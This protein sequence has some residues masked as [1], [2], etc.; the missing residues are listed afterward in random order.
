MVLPLAAVANPVS[1]SPLVSKPGL[2]ASS[3]GSPSPYEDLTPLH[4]AYFL[5]KAAANDA[6]AAWAAY[7]AQYYQQPTGTVPAQYPTNPAG[8]AQ[9]SGDQTQSAQTPG[10]QPD[11][12]KAWE[13]YYKRMGE[14]E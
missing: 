8:G 7:Y 1:V 12:S 2:Q 3:R 10:N 6:N 4:P 5:G 11:Y 9:T 14:T 13:E